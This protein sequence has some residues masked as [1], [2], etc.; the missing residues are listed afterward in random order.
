MSPKT[1]VSL[2][3]LNTTWQTWCPAFFAILLF[4]A[5][6]L[7]SAAT[8]KTTSAVLL[9]LTLSAVFLFFEKLRDRMGPPVLALVLVVLMDGVSVFYAPSGKYALYE[10]LKV[11][12]AFCL[13][14]LLLTAANGK[15]PGRQAAAAL[16]GCCAFAGLVSIDL[17]STRLISGPV[18]AFLGLFTTDY[19]NL[20]VVE[21]GVRILSIFMSPNVFAGCIGIGV[22][23]S[24]GLAATSETSVQYA[25]HLTCLFVS[26]LSFVL[27]FSMGAC[28]MIIPAFLLYLLCE[29]KELRL[30]QLLL[31]VETLVLVVL[32]AS[33]IS[34]TSMTAWTGIQPTPL[35]CTAIGAALLCTLDLLAGRRAAEKLRSHK[36]PLLY[37]SAAVLA[38]L[39]VYIIAACHLTTGTVLQPGETLRRSAYP[40]PGVYTLE[41]EADGRLLVSIES[42]NLPDAMM[43]TNTPLYQGTLAEAAFTVPE[44]SLVVHFSFTAEEPS[45]LTSVRYE[46]AQ[47]SGSIPL[48][49]RLLPGF[50]ANRIQGLFTNQ[51]AIQRLVFFRDGLKL[52]RR[53]PA[54][55]L[56]LGAFENGI[57]GVQSFYYTTKYVHNHYIQSLVDT[58][59]IGLTLFVGLLAV[60]VLSIWRSRA[61]QPLAPALGAALLYIAGH[62]AVEVD[63][64][65]YA[66]LPVAFC[67]FAAIDLCCAGTVSFPAWAGKKRLKGSILLGTSALMTAFA[68]MLNCNIIA[69]RTAKQAVELSELERA[70]ALDRFE[71]ADYMLTYVMRT[72]SQ[73]VDAGT[74]RT[75]DQYAARLAQLDSNAVP[76]YLAE[77]YLETGRINQGMEMLEKYVNYLSADTASWQRAFDLLARYETDSEEYQTGAARIASL[78]DA[79]NEK[80]PGQ[81]TLDEQALL[82]ADRMRR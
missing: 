78:L 73:E 29:R 20:Y 54:A 21:E 18:L 40:A 60:S 49:Y 82:F 65:Y 61:S 37:L 30:R 68:V 16:E 22:L 36:K 24:L 26:S 10:F 33:C 43:H 35:L 55:G 63:F 15:N 58:G 69:Q 8:I 27:A 17:I 56:G 12:A 80:N 19:Q 51:N 42:Q 72:S 39:I 41:A 13:A 79:W 48:Q 2:F 1:R 44:D 76:L 66:F 50:A 7:C 67:L 34:R 70:V 46:S 52:A 25:V 28:L 23:L 47:D 75:A 62:S 71:W 32:A 11:L 31:M 6:C 3:A 59:I 74:R 9:I 53:S 45:H 4:F 77:Y 57:K 5:V 14:L 81:I 38:C 64:S